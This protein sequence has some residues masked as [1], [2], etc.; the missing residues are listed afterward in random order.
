M[1]R[2]FQ[3]PRIRN[4]GGLGPRN[5]GT[6][7]GRKRGVSLGPTAET[8]EVDT[9]SKFALTGHVHFHMLP[10]HRAQTARF[11]PDRVVAAKD[12]NAEAGAHRN[13]RSKAEEFGFQ[14]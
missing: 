6:F 11:E 10:F 1:R 13:W 5:F 2:P 12:S 3:T 8:K 9:E 7:G 14:L 4:K